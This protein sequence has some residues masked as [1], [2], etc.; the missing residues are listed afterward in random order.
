MLEPRGKGLVA[1]TLRY[2][3]E[4][5]ADED[6]FEDLGD[7]KVPGEML[8]LATHI[9]DRKAGDF[10]PKLFEDRYQNGLLDLIKAK[11]AHRVISD[12]PSAPR[13]TNVVTLMDA[14]RKSIAA[15]GKDE[16]KGKDKPEGVD[17]P[18]KA[19]PAK[20]EKAKRSTAEK[21]KAEPAKAKRPA[22]EGAARSSGGARLKKAS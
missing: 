13:P 14:L 2:G 17:K 20:A 4:V 7:M 8:D 22:A 15:E 16:P 5:R 10:D 6:Y 12:A 3:Y 21:A 9:I 18:A 1:F 19:P 11:Q